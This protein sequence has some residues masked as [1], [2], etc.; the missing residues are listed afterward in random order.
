MA[1]PTVIEFHSRDLDSRISAREV[2]AVR[3]WQY[4]GKHFHVMRDN[5]AH[6]SRMLGGMFGVLITED[7]FS[8]SSMIWNKIYLQSKGQP[9]RKGYD[10]TLLQ[11]CAWHL[12]QD[13]LLAH[14]SYLCQRYA[15]PNNRP[16]PTKRIE[17]EPNNFVG[18]NGGILTAQC[19][20]KCRPVDHQDWIYC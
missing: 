8:T 2:A 7:Y 4:S 1:D 17:N 3:D 15:N 16:W 9:W 13:H 19:P 14:D 11:M 5:P 6:T 10:Q 18:S 12:I 20:K